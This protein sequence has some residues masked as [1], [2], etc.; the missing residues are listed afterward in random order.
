MSEPDQVVR[1]WWM[2]LET[3]EAFDA[4]V[5]RETRRMSR[6]KEAASVHP[7]VVGMGPKIQG[8]KQV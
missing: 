7:I 8:Q 3:R 4:A 5:M 1:S 6:S 2:D